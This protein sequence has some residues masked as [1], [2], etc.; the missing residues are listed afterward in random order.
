[1]VQFR[2]REVFVRREGNH[3]LAVA[4]RYREVPFQI[5][6]MRQR[7]LA[8][9][10]DRI[11]DLAFDA[12]R[13]AM[14]VQRVPVFG[15]DDI[16]VEDASVIRIAL[17]NPNA[18]HVLQAGIEISRILDP[19]FRDLPRLS[20]Q[21]IPDN[22]L[23]RVE[24]RVPAEDLDGVSIPQAMI[25]QKP[26]TIGDIVVVRHDDPA[27]SPNIQVLQRMQGEAPRD[28]ERAGAV[29]L[30]FRQDR[31]AG[32]LDQRKP[33]PLRD[34]LQAEHVRHVSGKMNRDDG[35]RSL[36]DRRLDLVDV[37]TKAV[38]AI[39]EHRFRTEFVDRADGR[40]E[41]VGRGDDL[42]AVPDTARLQRKLDRVRSGADADRV[43]RSDQF[44]ESAFELPQG[45]AQSEVAGRN[46]AAELV[47][48]LVD[49]REL[50][51]K[52]GIPDTHQNGPLNAGLGTSMGV[53]SRSV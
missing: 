30:R 50:L 32:I 12:G 14:F 3:L 2:A 33:V 18:G 5:A 9:D 44:R 11:V 1:M 47:Q 26:E 38:V 37:H 16:Q 43:L 36:R 23:E 27:I 6:E 17:R 22:G 21:P 51:G 35:F 53:D 34:R 42:V 48:D 29:P 8:V 52:V 4:V 41:G 49:I 24:A 39:D 45:G 10:R 25:A 40:D 31:L 7:R 46:E 28:S 19:P 15:E 13:F 20:D